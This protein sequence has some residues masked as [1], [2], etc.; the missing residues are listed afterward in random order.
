MKDWEQP[1]ERRNVTATHAASSRPVNQV[2]PSKVLQTDKEIGFLG[3]SVCEYDVSSLEQC[4]KQ[5]NCF[6]HTR[7]G[8]RSRLPE[9]SSDTIDTQNL[10]FSQTL[11]KL[12]Q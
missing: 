6:K 12:M 5:Q 2:R 1:A 8:L 10:L 9:N 3:N 7:K 11:R 4:S